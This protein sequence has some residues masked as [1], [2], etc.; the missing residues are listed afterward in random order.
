MFLL[1][2]LVTK[3]SLQPF[4][5][6]ALVGGTQPNLSFLLVCLGFIVCC[7]P[8]EA[9]EEGPG[10]MELKRQNSFHEI[11]ILENR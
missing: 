10:Q 2:F 3:T 6:K 11:A 5:V 8:S 7:S 4:E 1:P 9:Q